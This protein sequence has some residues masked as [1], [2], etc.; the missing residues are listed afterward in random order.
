M[1]R[2]AE[3]KDMPELLRMLKRFYD[4]SGYSEFVLYDKETV[5]QVF[6]ELIKN[7][8][9]LTDGKNAMLGFLVF[10]FFLNKN[11]LTAQELF[12][13]VDEDKRKTGIG[14]NLLK[15]AEKQAK[16]LGAKSLMMLNIKN[17]NGESV[18]KLYR[19]LGYRETEKTYMRGL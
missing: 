19:S 12:W 13:W 16:K 14:V 10:P 11:T 3:T 4:V 5:I 15:E 8:T 6:I 7:K 17:L 9:L 2:L 18:E 1:I